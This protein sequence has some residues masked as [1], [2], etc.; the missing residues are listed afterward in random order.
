M[1]RDVLKSKIVE[2]CNELLKELVVVTKKECK[3]DTLPL[4]T[5]SYLLFEPSGKNSY[6]GNDKTVQKTSFKEIWYKIQ[7]NITSGKNWQRVNTLVSRY[8]YDFS[9]KPLNPGFDIESQYL[10]PLFNLYFSNIREIKYNKLAARKYISSMINRLDALGCGLIGIGI[11]SNFKAET[12]FKL[13][14]NITIRPISNKD[15]EM[16]LGLSSFQFPSHPDTAIFND[17]W[18]IEI[19][20]FEL[21]GSTS[22]EHMIYET[23]NN[24]IGP[25][26]RMFKPG[27]MGVKLG[28]IRSASNFGISSEARG[29]MEKRT[30]TGTSEYYLSKL[31]IRHLKKYWTKIQSIVHDQE[32]YLKV[33]LRRMYHSGTRTEKEDSIIDYVI[34]LEALLGTKNEK[35]EIGFRFKTRG[36]VLLAKTKEER[37]VLMEKLGKLYGLRSSIAHG[38]YVANGIFEEYLPFAENS[39]RTIWK[40]YFDKY[41]HEKNNNLGVKRIDSD[42]VT[43]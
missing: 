26:F 29:G 23:I 14:K 25:I 9:N 38:N 13:A 20:L 12:P 11:L 43:R 30:R 34:G 15:I 18:V 19:V 17:W 33:P 35:T 21:N 6:S 7:N 32:H 27:D 2:Q 4:T 5:T 24:E 22:S 28:I 41:S 3:Q 39:L 42:F 36:A 1:E 37:P 8:T 16:I 40:W 10:L 31:D